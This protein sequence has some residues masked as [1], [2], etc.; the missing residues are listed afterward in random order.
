MI[1]LI[2][3]KGF[4][5]VFYLFYLGFVYEMCEDD[6]EFKVIVVDMVNDIG[7]EV[8]ICQQIVLIW[9]LDVWF[10]LGEIICFSLV[11]VG[12]GDW[13]IF[14]DFVWE[15]YVY[16]FGSEFIVIEGSGYLL[17]FE[18]LDKVM[19]VFWDFLNKV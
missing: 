9:W 6:E 7:F 8:F 18:E 11:L 19:V 16:I 15:I 12:D 10:C 13:L 17:M 1:K 5:K 14:F 2:C 4:K 3:E